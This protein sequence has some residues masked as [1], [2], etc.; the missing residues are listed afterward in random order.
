[1]LSARLFGKESD[2]KKKESV[3][4][5]HSSTTETV[6]LPPD[7]TPDANVTVHP[8]VVRSKLPLKKK[9][10][11]RGK[12]SREN[13]PPGKIAKK[14]IDKNL[15]K[16]MKPLAKIAEE[17]PLGKVRN[18]L[19]HSHHLSNGLSSLRKSKSS[20]AGFVP[21][22][23][24]SNDVIVAPLITIATEA[25]VDTLAGVGETT[26][27][28]CEGEGKSNEMEVK[29]QV[30]FKPPFKFSVKLRKP[31]KVDVKKKIEK[32]TS[33]N[34]LIENTSK[35][36]EETPATEMKASGGKAA[37]VAKHKL[38][39]DKNVPEPV[40]KRA[41]LLIRAD[42]TLRRSPKHGKG[43]KPRPPADL[44]RLISQ[45]SANSNQSKP[46]EVPCEPVYENS[47]VPAPGRDKLEKLQK[48][49]RNVEAL[50]RRQTS[51]ENPELTCYVASD[52]LIDISGD[53]SKRV[54]PAKDDIRKKHRSKR[55]KANEQSKST[56]SPLEKRHSMSD[57][58]T[59]P[60]NCDQPEATSFNLKHSTSEVMKVPDDVSRKPSKRHSSRR[61]VSAASDRKRHSMSELPQGP[62]ATSSHRIRLS[63][64]NNTPD[65]SSNYLASSPH[66]KSDM[67][68]KR[69]SM[70]DLPS[71]MHIYENLLDTELFSTTNQNARS[72]TRASLNISRT[73]K[74]NPPSFKRHSHER[75][76]TN[77]A[78]CSPADRR[79]CN[80]SSENLHRHSNE[81][82]RSSSSLNRSSNPTHSDKRH[83]TNSSSSNQ[84]PAE[85][86]ASNSALNS[87]ERTPRSNSLNRSQ[88]S[89]H[90]GR[91][92]E[93]G[94]P[95]NHTS[96]VK[97]P[98]SPH[99]SQ[100]SSFNSTP[101]S[102]SSSFNAT[103]VS[104]NTSSHDLMRFPSLE[105]EANTRLDYLISGKK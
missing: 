14:L 39:A 26:P 78:S 47:E 93:S 83:K 57:V 70:S 60:S 97:S 29:L 98:T 38:L 73:P 101:V 6:R 55:K 91:Q 22:E 10:R 61:D 84:K 69:H 68:S 21:M 17:D 30:V 51:T 88:S 89:N 56:P 63:S 104:R 50:V 1:M 82:S 79:S 13:D 95:H 43:G 65:H 40:K 72:G 54:N 81:R 23:T 77:G 90:I 67:D 92:R 25:P 74:N 19:L 66:E 15:K 52:D 45:E 48:H 42:K 16:N 100:Y 76:K 36:A 64:S 85:R 46:D 20:P 34:R 44:A 80:V 71:Q 27:P 105:T 35:E 31:N 59:V 24:P 32:S 41:A 99:V 58:P 9:V 87:N 3:T 102:H 94:T 75:V 12:K 62:P 7:L 33:S 96:T 18:W 103:P 37:K 5:L 49:S 53:V 11:E 86:Y 4:I 8:A 2:R 28:V